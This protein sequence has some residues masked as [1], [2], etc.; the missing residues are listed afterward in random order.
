MRYKI[1]LTYSLPH[2]GYQFII[3]RIDE[4]AQTFCTLNLTMGK[5]SDHM[6]GEMV[7]DVALME[8]RDVLELANDL[9]QAGV[10]PHDEAG[11]GELA[12]KNNHIEDLR[13]LLFEDERTRPSEA[14]S[15]SRAGKQGLDSARP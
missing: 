1:S 6:P 10:R 12:A 4:D 5:W 14:A 3:S 2:R 11:P 13:R 7:L 15:G 9:K 8:E